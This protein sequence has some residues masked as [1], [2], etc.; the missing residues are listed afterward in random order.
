MGVKKRAGIAVA[1]ALSLSML[2]F[3]PASGAGVP[4]AP[5]YLKATLQVIVDNDYAAFFGDAT[6][7]TRLFHQNNVGWGDQ[8]NNALSLDIFP[9][10]GE[11]Y[12][13]LA[14]MGGGGQEDWAGKLNGID[15]VDI[16]GAQVA[17][18]RSPLGAGAITY[19]YMTLQGFVPG[20]SLA[21]VEAG[22]QNITLAQLQTALTGISWSSAVSTGAGSGFVPNHK[23][24]GVCCQSGNGMSG[25]GWEFSTESIVVFRYPVTGLDLPV[26]GA[27]SQVIVD[28]DAPAF[29][30]APTNYVVQYKKTS[31]A[32]SAYVTFSNPTA[33]TTIETVTGLTNGVSYSFRVAGTNAF[34]TGAYSVAR[35]ATPIGPPPP[36]TSLV[37]TAKA[38]SADVSFTNPIS[39]GGAT[40]TNYQYSLNNG[41]SWTSLSPADTSTPVTIPGLTDGVTSS[42][43]LRAVNSYGPGPASLAVSII[44]GL[45]ER[46]SNLTISSNPEKGVL[47]TITVSLSVAGKLNFLINGKRIPGCY[48]KSSSGS[49]PDI[50][51]T[52]SWKPAV[53]GR[54]VITVQG[55][56]NDNSYASSTLTSPSINVLRRSTRR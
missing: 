56:A 16:A 17:T 2:S 48:K 18:G 50:T 31:E 24:T 54:N 41:S 30:D 23:T 8:I 15:V 12:L 51:G 52:C 28:W 7:V 37:A 5:V 49:P 6:N 20:Y 10:S 33:S 21:A 19:G 9:Q 55:V 35:T 42:I 27:D 22:T 4:Q 40:I 45:V 34:G 11:T 44:P 46:L 13:Y 43:Q 3:Q 29:G 32:D 38:S 1:I 53:I 36:P 25:K 26:R 47:T 14:V 39:D